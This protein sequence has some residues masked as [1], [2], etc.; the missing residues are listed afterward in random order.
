[1][2]KYKV[3]INGGNFLINMEDRTAKYGFFTTRF[4][5]ATD[6]AAAENAAVKMIRDVSRSLKGC[7][8][9]GPK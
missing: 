5:E 8:F 1:M 3:K 4:L 6:S 7:H 9:R 2:P